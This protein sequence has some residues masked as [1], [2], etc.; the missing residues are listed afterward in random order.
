MAPDESFSTLSWPSGPR[1]A[2]VAAARTWPA[3]K[4]NML[5][6]GTGVPDGKRRRLPAAA[7]W[8]AVTLSTTERAAAGMPH[9]PVIGKVRALAAARAGPPEGPAGFLVSATRQG[10]M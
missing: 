3:R 10:V 1:P 5:V 7:G 2:T 4:F 9:R 8:I 6:P